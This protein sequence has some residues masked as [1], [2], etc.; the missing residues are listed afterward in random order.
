M[1]GVGAG[2]FRHLF[3]R[4]AGHDL[5][6]AIAALQPLVKQQPG[7]ISAR[8]LLA[9]AY[10]GRGELDQADEI[11]VSA[12]LPDRDIGPLSLSVFP[13]GPNHVT[14]PAVVLPLPGTWTIEVVARYGEFEEVRFRVTLMVGRAT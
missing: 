9:E 1:A 14:N 11:T 2:D 6:A 5:P 13:A 7:L 8:V 12:T 3:G 10:R 4:S